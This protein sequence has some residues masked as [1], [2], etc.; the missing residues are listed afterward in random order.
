MQLDN[1]VICRFRFTCTEHWGDLMP[2]ADDP[3]KRFCAVCKTPVHLTSS[4]E[5]LAINI[6]AKRCV[7]IFLANPDGPTS[8]FMGDIC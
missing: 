3:T 4:Y 1:N 5:E 7:A 8:E 2:F 6:A